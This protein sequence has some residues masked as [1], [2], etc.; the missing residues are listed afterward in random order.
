VVP[1]KLYKN[2]LLPYDL[3]AKEFVCWTTRTSMLLFASLLLFT[4]TPF[5]PEAT[6]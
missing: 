6:M 4:A 2:E 1:V 5:R 3:H